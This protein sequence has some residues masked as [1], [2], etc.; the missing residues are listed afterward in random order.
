MSGVE[1]VYENKVNYP[2]WYY[3]VNKTTPF[4]LLYFSKDPIQAKVI[5]YLCRE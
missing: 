2:E 3:P 1:I 4:G 5:A